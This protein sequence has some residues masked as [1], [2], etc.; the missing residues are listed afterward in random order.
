MPN[1]QDN[2]STNSDNSNSSEYTPHKKKSGKKKRAKLR[3][4]KSGVC[5]SEESMNAGN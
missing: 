4:Q 1:F 5:I 2:C 3:K